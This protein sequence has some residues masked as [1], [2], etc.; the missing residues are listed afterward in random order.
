MTH[1]WTEIMRQDPILIQS[2]AHIKVHIFSQILHQNVSPEAGLT[3]C[4]PCSQHLQ[5]R[6]EHRST[7]AEQT[8]AWLT[9]QL[10]EAEDDDSRA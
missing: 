2:S 1:T 3:L 5:Q 7:A 6:L 8:K 9:Q 4:G 10:S